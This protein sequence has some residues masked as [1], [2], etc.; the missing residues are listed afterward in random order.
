MLIHRLASTIVL[1]VALA[2]GAACGTSALPSAAT[3]GTDIFLTPDTIHVRGLIPR[4]TTLDGILRAQG[5]AAGAVADVIAAARTVFDPRRLRSSQPFLLVTTLEGALRRFEYEIDADSILR[6]VPTDLDA[7]A[8]RAELVPIPRRLE[9]ATAS[10]AIGG[11][12]PSLYQAMESTG[13]S[14]EL[15][16]ALAQIFSGEIDF[17]TEV[18]PGDRFAL[19]FEKFIRE[20]RPSVT[21][22]AI[23][24]AE[25]HN[26]GRV[27]R[28]IRFTPPGGRPDYFDEQGRSL[29]RFFLRSPLRFDPRIT[30]RFS[31]RR[32]HP[33]LGTA[34]AHNGVDYGAPTGAQ[35]VAV[36]SG[37]VVSATY[38]SANGC[39][40][41]LRHSN[42]Y[43]TYYLHLSAFGRGIRAGARVEQGQTIGLVGSTGLATG[44]HLHYGLQKSGRWV[45]PLREHRNM[46]PGDPVPPTAMDAFRAARDAGLEQLAAALTGPDPSGV[47][48][49][50]H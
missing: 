43:Q 18:Q 23:M 3:L 15:T 42:G 36:A 17:N 44:P 45:D 39:M 30:S 40:V 31:T 20:D 27:V 5:L 21:Y 10:G 41:R 16:I 25:F 38:D 29:R 49:A 12:T 14:P 50:T 28:A 48:A 46:P 1:L 35:A 13:E 47:I 26:D 37:T 32:M 22:G 4:N 9:H 11:A 24:A 7:S 8:L 2:G 34:R 6:I 19:A 33:I